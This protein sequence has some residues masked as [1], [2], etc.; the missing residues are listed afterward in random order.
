MHLLPKLQIPVGIPQN[1]EF[2]RKLL[3]IR[4]EPRSDVPFFTIVISISIETT[5]LDPRCDVGMGRS[6][7]EFAQLP[8]KCVS[9]C[10]C[11]LDMSQTIFWRTSLMHCQQSMMGFQHLLPH[12]QLKSRQSCHHGHWHSPATPLPLFNTQVMP[13]Q[14]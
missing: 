1:S 4:T 13:L 2:C 6:H 7:S 5:Y 8:H 11:G 9:V 3:P 12:L 14:S 10:G